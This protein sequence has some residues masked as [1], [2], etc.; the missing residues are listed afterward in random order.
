MIFKNFYILIHIYKNFKITVYS[1]IFI[2]LIHNLKWH[3]GKESH[4]KI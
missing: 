4:D 3:S 1:F 2:N